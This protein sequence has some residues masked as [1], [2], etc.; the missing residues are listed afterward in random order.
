MVGAHKDG[1]D[2]AQDWY[3]WRALVNAVINLAFHKMRRIFWLN[4]ELVAFQHGLYSTE[5][6]SLIIWICVFSIQQ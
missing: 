2:L 1:V 5:W 3:K 4:E 6:V